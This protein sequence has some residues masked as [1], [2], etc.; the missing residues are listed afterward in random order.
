MIDWF[1]ILTPILLLFVIALLG[2]V[3]CDQVLGLTEVTPAVTHVQTTVQTGAS[4]TSTITADALT[5]AGGELILVTV[6][7]KSAGIPSATPSL[8]GTGTS[9]TGEPI[10]NNASFAPVTVGGQGTGQYFWNGLEIQSFWATNPAANTSL[11]VQVV[12]M[13]GANQSNSASIW[14]LCVSAYKDV[15]SGVA[16]YSP[17][18]SATNYVGLTPSTAAINLGTHDLLYAVGFAADA[19]GTFPGNNPLVAGAGLV[20]EFPAVSNPLVEDGGV[21]STIAGQVSNT[22]A[23]L[24]PKGFVL[25]M[26][27]KGQND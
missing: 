6:Q 8:T 3:G 9:P 23:N 21:N 12:L 2:F 11:T 22:T 20:A 24:N 25:A 10:L 17:Q 16:P 18:A 4:G 27:I 19:N 13:T 14:N 15:Q 26:G 7:W 5:L 1:V